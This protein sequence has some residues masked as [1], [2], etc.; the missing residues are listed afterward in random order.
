MVAEYQ[1]S[2]NVKKIFSSLKISICMKCPM[3]KKKLNL[4]IGHN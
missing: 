1:C 4:T 2:I 3:I